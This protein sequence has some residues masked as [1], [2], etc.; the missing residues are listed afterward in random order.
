MGILFLSGRELAYGRNALILKLLAD[1]YPVDRI[2][3][4]SGRASIL[5]ESIK[6]ALQA[7]PLIRTGKYQLIVVGF[8]GHFQMLP[9]GVFARPAV[10]FDAF[11]SAYDTLC[12]DRQVFA[13]RSLPGRMAHWLD[14]SACQLSNR[15]LLDTQ[16][17]VKYF[18]QEF[19]IPQEKFDVLFVGC[20]DEVFFPRSIQPD[21]ETVL[22]YG[23][24][25][26][27]HGI[28][29]ILEA[30]RL[31]HMAEPRVKFEMIGA[32]PKALQVNQEDIAGMEGALT[33][34]PPVPFDQL[35]G[36]IAAAAVC[37]GG[38]FGGSDKAARVIASKTFQCLA[39]GRPVIVGDNQANRELLSHAKD[40]WMCRPNDPRALADAI[41]LLI[42][43]PDLRQRLGDCG[44]QTY[45][46]KASNPI[47]QAHLFQ[48]VEQTISLGRG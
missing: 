18:V 30:A 42:H 6:G 34:E 21:P 24:F 28:K 4:A 39:M 44:R 41:L 47:L 3:K 37:L 5:Q 46:A 45:L 19:G 17:H 9:I 20:D 25:L 33:V 29:T 8:F 48:I 1:R 27:L 2:G 13:P 40:T 14:R 22:F 23:S 16:A 11:I 43:D 31:V 35:P 15:I 36:R 32:D 26:P 38:H 12:F 7:L 10:L